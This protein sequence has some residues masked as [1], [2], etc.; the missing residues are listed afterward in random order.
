[1]YRCRAFRRGIRARRSIPCLVDVS[2]AI[3]VAE[4][5]GAGPNSPGQTRK[6]RVADASDHPQRMIG[7][8]P[9]LQVHV[10]EQRRTNPIIPKHTRL[11]TPQSRDEETRTGENRYPLRQPPG[12]FPT[13][14]TARL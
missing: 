9:V 7:A 4:A 12:S 1:M 13:T 10:A 14:L 3:L 2:G 11:P 5:L 6:C 8:H